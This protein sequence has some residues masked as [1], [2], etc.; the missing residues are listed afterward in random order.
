MPLTGNLDR[1]QTSGLHWACS[2]AGRSRRGPGAALVPIE[3]AGRALSRLARGARKQPG[4]ARECGEAVGAH[5][6]SAL[7]LAASTHTRVSTH[8]HTLTQA[9]LPA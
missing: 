6:G 1:S 7:V 5:A 3:T 2:R 8:T 9:G 4:A